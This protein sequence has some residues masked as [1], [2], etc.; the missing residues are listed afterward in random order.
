[1]C[2]SRTLVMVKVTA[3]ECTILMV[4]LIVT[5]T[6]MQTNIYSLYPVA[7]VLPVQCAT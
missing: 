5:P 2:P 3:N 1:M 7:K 4:V 6:G